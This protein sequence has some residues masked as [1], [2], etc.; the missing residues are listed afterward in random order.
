MRLENDPFTCRIPHLSLS[1]LISVMGDLPF[2]SCDGFMG[3]AL[4][5][6]LSLSLY[7]TGFHGS[8]SISLSLC[9]SLYL[10]VSLG[11]SWVKALSLSMGVVCSNGSM[12]QAPSLSLPSLFQSAL[13]RFRGSISIS[14]SPPSHTG[15]HVSSSLSSQTFWKEVDPSTNFLTLNASCEK[16]IGK[17]AVLQ[18]HVDK[19]QSQGPSG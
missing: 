19:S 4:S 14:I 3:K 10:C 6:S 18:T 16:M 13:M 9:L 7:P 15:F 11:D 17:A 2:L 1:L 12:G 5:L 8:G